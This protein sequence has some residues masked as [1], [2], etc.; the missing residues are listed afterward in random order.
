MI[1]VGLILLI[2]VLLRLR[3]HAEV[4]G[5][6][7]IKRDPNKA[8]VLLPNHPAE[9]DPVILM[10]WLYPHFRQRPLVVEKY[11][12]VRG[13]AWLMRYIKAIPIPDLKIKPTSWNLFKTQKQMKLIHSLCEEK[14]ALMI[15]PAGIVKITGKEDL[16]ASAIAYELVQSKTPIQFVLVRTT[17]LWGSSFSRFKDGQMPDFNTTLL[18]GGLICLMNAIFFTPRRKVVIE[19]KSVD[20]EELC[21]FDKTGLNRY[22]ESWYDQYPSLDPLLDGQNKVTDTEVPS[23]V[24]YSLLWRGES[25]IFLQKRKKNN[26]KAVSPEFKKEV[27]AFLLTLTKKQQIDWTS[28]TELGRQLNLDSLELAELWIFLSK[29]YNLT[30]LEVEELTTVGDLYQVA[31]LASNTTAQVHIEKK[32]KLCERIP[33]ILPVYDAQAQTVLEAIYIAGV[34]RQSQG[35]CADRFAG[36]LTYKKFARAICLLSKE[37]NKCSLGGRKEQVG[38]LLPASVGAYIVILSTLLAGKVPVMLNWTL[39]KKHLEECVAQAKIQTIISSEKFLV[40]LVH[41]D[42]GSIC[43]KI[44]LTED[45]KNKISLGKVIKLLLN[46]VFP[47]FKKQLKAL[48]LT[49]DDHAVVLFT[50]GTE[51]PPKVVPLSHE[52][53]MT[54]HRAAI[55]RIAL[56]K[57]DI[58]YAMLPP[59]HS[60][61]FSIAGLLPLLAGMRVY[62][63]ANPTQTLQIAEDMV[64]QRPT[65]L[66]SPP[67]FLRPLLA[68]LDSKKSELALRL[69]VSGAEAMPQDLFNLA[70]SYSFELIEGYGITE[71]SPIVS[72][73][74]PEGKAPTFKKFLERGIGKPL[75]GIELAIINHDSLALLQDG[76]EGEI[77]VS[78][79]SVFAGYGNLDKQTCFIEL[80]GKQFYKSGDRGKI[81]NGI[82]YLTGRYKRFVKIG[83]EMIHLGTIEQMLIEIIRSQ[84]QITEPFALPILA[85]VGVEDREHKT[86]IFLFIT[87]KLE[88]APLQEALRS[89]GLSPLIKIDQLVLVDSIP[90]TGTGKIDYLYLEKSAKTK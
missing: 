36:V 81:E 7:A 44:I 39:G 41:A 63:E 2:K 19:L 71:C 10:T 78:G 90:L 51:G 17:G 66:C 18:K 32:H 12:Y 26:H 55:K 77:C 76:E 34:Q 40:E 25:Q 33:T 5:L 11:Y 87:R 47:Q 62:Y 88:K 24:P 74:I 42:L 56:Y 52:N 85:V 1:R 60:F 80:R 69:V 16:G 53:I 58:F 75:D 70:G 49:K 65:I 64:S 54:N 61:G 86:Q 43:D 29:K 27:D 59:F 72:L 13:F 31:V 89:K 46:G 4:R 3:Y 57:E 67:S 6:R 28:E 68:E 45:L 8:L 82:L 38:I 14:E 73:Q 20:A 83:G 15:Y 21:Q 23:N 37:I 48:K 30:G 35:I 79:K 22:L 84:E 9:I 50:S